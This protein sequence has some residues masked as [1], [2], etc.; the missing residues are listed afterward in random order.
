LEKKVREKIA[1]NNNKNKSLIPIKA[2]KNQKNKK[3]PKK[4]I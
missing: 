4:K 1:K 3:M 2:E